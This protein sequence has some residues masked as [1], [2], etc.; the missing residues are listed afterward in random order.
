[1]T[2]EGIA[3]NALKVIWTATITKTIIMPV[4]PIIVTAENEHSQVFSK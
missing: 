2:A 4:S 1:M 3:E